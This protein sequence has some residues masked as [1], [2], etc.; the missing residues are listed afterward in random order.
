MKILGA[1]GEGGASPHRLLVS[2]IGD[3]DKTARLV[4]NQYAASAMWPGQDPS[5]RCQSRAICRHPTFSARQHIL[6]QRITGLARDFNAA[7]HANQYR[8]AHW[9]SRQFDQSGEKLYNAVYDSPFGNELVAAFGERAVE[10]ENSGS[11]T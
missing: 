8:G 1:A 11:A 2:T 3:A 9:L 7:H 6:L 4:S 10:A 5:S